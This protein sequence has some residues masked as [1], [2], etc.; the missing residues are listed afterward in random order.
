MSHLQRGFAFA[1]A[2]TPSIE[3]SKNEEVT[4]VDQGPME[5]RDDA[6]V[7]AGSRLL[8]RTLRHR[9]LIGSSSSS[10]G[11]A[12][13]ESAIN[14]IVAATMMLPRFTSIVDISDPTMD[15]KVIDRLEERRRHV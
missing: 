10:G 15:A 14:G 4:A 11:R 1:S 8:E 3:S 5:D 7:Q 9:A 6:R 13:V 12:D 2:T